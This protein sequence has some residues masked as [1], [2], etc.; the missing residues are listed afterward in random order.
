MPG[1]HW[2]TQLDELLRR[3]RLPVQSA[4]ARD[5]VVTVRAAPGG[6]E[7]LV[8]LSPRERGGPHF[9]RVGRHLLRYCAPRDL[10]PQ[11]RPVIEAL[12]RIMA[13]FE[14]LVPAGFKEFHAIGGCFDDPGQELRTRFPFAFVERSGSG[15]D[16][17]TEILLR[18]TQAC[19]QRCP[20]C[21]APPVSQATSEVFVECLQFVCERFRGARLTLTGGEPT[22]RAAF[23]EE[24]EAALAKTELSAVQ[25]QTNAVW[26]AQEAR[27]ARIPHD[28]RLS[29]FVSLHATEPAVYDECTGTR[30]QLPLALA[31]IRNL[32]RAGHQVTLNS[33]VNRA[34]LAHLAQLVGE[35]PRVFAGLTLPNLHFSVLICPEGKPEAARYLVRYTDLAPALEA[36]AAKAGQAGI[37]VEPLVSSTHASLPLCL[38]SNQQRAAS[39]NRPRLQEGET[40]YEDFGRSWVKAARC[41]ACAFTDSCLGLPAPYALR[42]GFD[43]LSPIA[44]PASSKAEPG[45]G[46]QQHGR[47]AP[48]SGHT[49][50]LPIPESIEL[51]RV[52]G[53][54][55]TCTRPWTTLEITDPR[56]AARQCC[57]DWTADKLGDVGNSTLLE[58]W[59]GAGFVAARQAMAA[60]V[61]QKCLAVCPRLHDGQEHERRLQIIGG[62]ERFVRNQLRIAEDIALR[63]SET[64]AMPLF[65]T[66]CPSTFCNASCVM[67]LH[68]RE[69]R[70]DLPE[71]VW[72]E[73]PEFFP[74]LV[75]LTLLG[76]EPLANPRVWQLLREADLD[77]YPDFSVDLIT[78]GGL[79]NEGAL[80]QIRGAALG[81]VT[82]SLNAGTAEAYERVQRGLQ[83][84][85]VIGN[86][87]A[88]LRFREAH[89]RWFGVSVSC[90]VQPLT[91]DSLVA[92]G[93]IARARNLHIR[94]LPLTVPKIPEL[95]FYGSPEQVRLVV[96]G[97]DRFE[98]WARGVNPSW[99]REIES[100]RRAVLAEHA[101]RIK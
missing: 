19:N 30:G 11:H 66:L 10:A 33:V 35:L 88:L 55:V 22:L 9:A 26:L 56:E 43:E 62:S 47:R 95:D 89:P 8:E 99:V 86:L 18:A 84:E 7:I 58:L 12:L 75:R 37:H 5:G 20:F 29:F 76:G 41:R 24:L 68:W 21:S 64:T 72:D 46:D 71:R 36:A 96:A 74:T 48:V 73:L 39:R 60:G 90:V 25:V 34:N 1:Q 67:C 51:L 44:A 57:A 27:V 94:L 32:L 38:V 54:E 79:L 31:G 78:N 61:G 45:E 13:R 77:K 42:F 65:L 15:D 91:I 16:A 87:D 97:L 81:G 17:E 92:F 52:P 6:Q 49:R 101:G 85:Q 70:Q 82:V 50:T 93:E 23:F 3:A 83:F 4:V 40:G 59:N 63:R 28:P 98:A 69:P 14:P 53:P 80:R 2:L 100:A